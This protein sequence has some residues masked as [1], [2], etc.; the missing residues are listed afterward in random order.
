MKISWASRTLLSIGIIVLSGCIVMGVFVGLNWTKSGSFETSLNT[1][2]ATVQNLTDT[3]GVQQATIDMLQAEMGTADLTGASEV[4]LVETGE[5]H[6]WHVNGVA[7]GT[8]AYEYYSYTIFNL[9]RYFVEFTGSSTGFPALTYSPT[10]ASCPGGTRAYFTH[11]TI[12]DCSRIPGDFTV[13]SLINQQHNE[14]DTLQHFLQTEFDK[15][16]F[17]GSGTVVSAR[18]GNSYAPCSPN[19][20][21][22]T[23]W[24]IAGQSGI[25]GFGLRAA[26]YS[27]TDG[28]YT[29]AFN[30]FR[31]PIPNAIT[32][33][34]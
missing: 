10:A 26:V 31:V 5:C 11:F 7:E 32:I 25:P 6:F 17:S 29:L 2:T 24:G 1:L 8:V 15:I 13:A 34:K 22:L 18:I 9:T 27:T 16:T 20:Y 12:A 23:D 4:T 14:A 19:T 21:V 33:S 28:P 3:V 30:Q